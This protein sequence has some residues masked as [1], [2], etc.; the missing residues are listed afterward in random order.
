MLS[1]MLSLL[2][3]FLIIFS[4]DRLMI[5]ISM[6]FLIAVF[7]PACPFIPTSPFINF[8]D[9]CKPPHLLHHP[10]LLFWQKFSSL[11]IYSAL[12]FYLNLESRWK[13]SRYSFYWNLYFYRFIYFVV[14]IPYSL[15]TQRFML[16]THIFLLNPSNSNFFAHNC[17]DNDQGS[18]AAH[19]SMEEKLMS[20]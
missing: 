5:F 8:G 6:K 3:F 4:Q 18:Q 15:S 20:V 17:D 16:R 14:A 1:I 10:R 7:L 2:M 9:F 12:L 19:A 13:T 11:P